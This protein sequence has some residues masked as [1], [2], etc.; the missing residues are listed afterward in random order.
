MLTFERAVDFARRYKKKT[1]FKRT[2]RRKG[3]AK[4]QPGTMPNLPA[5]KPTEPVKTASTTTVPP[6]RASDVDVATVVSTQAQQIGQSTTTPSHTA[7][8]SEGNTA[9]QFASIP[10]ISVTAIGMEMQLGSLANLVSKLM[11]KARTTTNTMYYEVLN[12]QIVK[13]QYQIAQL[14][15]S[16]EAEKARA[17]LDG[18]QQADSPGK[19]KV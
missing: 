9:V 19:P 11:V 6:S 13:L 2:I 7:K 14:S 4:G 18:Q 5:Q 17:V 12:A 3:G 8:E 15:L 10:T 1:T 16:L